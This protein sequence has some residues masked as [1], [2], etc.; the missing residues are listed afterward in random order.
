PVLGGALQ[1]EAKRINGGAALD[2]VASAERELRA[3]GNAQIL[4]RATAFGCYDHNLVA[5]SQKVQAPEQRGARERLWHVRA[6]Q[7]VLAT[8]S[9]ERPMVFS[10]ND[11]PGIMLSSAAMSYAAQYAVRPG[12]RVVFVTSGDFAYEAAADLQ[13]RGIEI[14]SIV[15]T[16]AEPGDV[17]SLARTAGITVIPGHAPVRAHGA[18][19]VTSLEVQP[20]AGTTGAGHKSS[21]RHLKC[22]V[23]CVSGGWTPTVHLFSQAR[24][25][26]RYD[27][28]R[29]ALLP[30]AGPKSFRCAGAAAGSF[31]LQHCLSDG[32]AAGGD[33][34]QAAGAKRDAG[35]APTAEPESTGLSAFWA[36]PRDSR[37]K[38][39]VDLQNDVTRADLELAVRENL[40]S[41]EHIKRYTTT[42]MAVDQ[43][44]TSNMNALGLIAE[45][46]DVSIQEIGTTTF[47]PPYDPVT[48]GTLA[49]RRVGPFY[50]PL[51]RTP[52][53]RWHA[54][55]GGVLEDFGGW[56]RP[57]W[58]AAKGKSREDCIRAEKRAARGA[59]SLFEGSP[60]GKIEVRGP[61]AAVFLNRMYYNNMRTLAVGRGR[62]GLMLS[63]HGIIID[64]GVCLR[65]TEDHFLVST[66]SGGAGRIFGGFEEWLQCEWPDLKV[67]VT[68]VTCAWG[69]IAIAGPR[70]RE[71]L[72]RLGMAIDLDPGAFPH[73]SIRCG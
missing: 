66:T 9:I 70:A 69:N 57:A 20:L 67:L 32:F 34:A 68:N 6:A 53:D 8:G 59:A 7:V 38:A 58:Y 19:A 24:G 29:A 33:A 36:A 27:P 61:D 62:Y 72:Q 54:E 46:T 63:E 31:A 11:L 42:G 56:Q 30:A 39:W 13:S 22:D 23:V 15:D 10:D 14:A 48:L 12:H 60:L 3:S 71:L 2:W 44:K 50:H 51:R 26:L 45:L 43:G 16:R 4:T 40:R 35:R 1:W 21:A 47:R 37:R 25:Q 28:E 65:L 18:R 52:L 17:A 55:H 5:L 49:G 64:D 73:L 41:V